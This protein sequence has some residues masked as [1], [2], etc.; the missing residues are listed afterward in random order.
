M[1]EQKYTASANV[2]K[3]QQTDVTDEGRTDN[4]MTIDSW[5]QDGNFYGQFDD[6]GPV[7]HQE[8]PPTLNGDPLGAAEKNSIV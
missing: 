5:N 1:E 2:E 3:L 8:A 7:L 6:F 4:F